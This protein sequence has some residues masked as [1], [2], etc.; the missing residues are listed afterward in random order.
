MTYKEAMDHLSSLPTDHPDYVPAVCPGCN[1][2]S[3]QHS[4]RQ[5]LDTA[6]L[7]V[8][9][10]ECDTCAAECLAPCVTLHIESP[11][12]EIRA[13]ALAQYAAFTGA[14]LDGVIPYSQTLGRYIV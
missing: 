5:V 2:T 6:E 14:N 10:R 7:T 1:H 11:D 12:D 13:E 4:G 8:Y 9:T 3:Y